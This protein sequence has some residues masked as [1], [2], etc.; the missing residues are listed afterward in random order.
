VRLGSREPERDRLREVV[1]MDL[2]DLDSVQ[3]LAR[4]SPHKG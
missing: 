2:A 3:R 1:A 4:P